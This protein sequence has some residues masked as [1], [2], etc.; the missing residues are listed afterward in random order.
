MHSWFAG[1]LV[2]LNHSSGEKFL[3][4]LKLTIHVPIFKILLKINRN[5]IVQGSACR[6]VKTVKY[7]Y[8]VYTNL[9]DISLLAIS[10]P[11]K[12]RYTLVYV[13]ITY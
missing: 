13:Y 12:E 11:Q 4:Y 1:L 8:Y 5:K 9:K 6:I 7:V 3:C 2:L 10:D